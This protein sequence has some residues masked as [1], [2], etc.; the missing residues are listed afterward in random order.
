MS[1]QRCGL[2]AIIGRPNVGKSTLLNH[3]LGQKISITSRK[4]QTTRHRIL[5]VETIDDDQM[6]FVD[7]PGLHRDQ[8]KALNR[9][10]NKAALGSMGDV[11]VIVMV[12][13][14]PEWSEEDDL[15]AE[16]ALSV[17]VPVV[18]VINKIDRIDQ[19]QSLLPAMQV[20]AEQRAFSA[21]VPVS[22]LRSKHLDDL[23][24]EI[25]QYL[26]ETVHLFPPDQIT[27]RSERFLVAE[28]VREKLVR[29]LGEE[30]P[31]ANTV[32]IEEFREDRGIVHISALIIVE[33]AGQKAIVIGRGGARLKKVG[34]E[35]RADIQR[36]LDS[37]VMLKL[38]VKV[39]SGWAD[40]ERALRSLGYV[41]DQ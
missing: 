23:L 36:L 27:D 29:Q 30:L 40:D 6:V 22:A 12:V 15:I 19:K 28:I 32:Q 35:A 18:L 17:G 31:Y 13:D 39:R 20:I 14:R 7:T 10:M 33:K 38:W 4:P 16:R 3:I 1:A 5:G 24:R 34:E 11:D 8:G 21:I 25:R 37:K 9:V 26:P 2:I 41:E